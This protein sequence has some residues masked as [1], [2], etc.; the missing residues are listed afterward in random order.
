MIPTSGRATS[1]SSAI[2]PR[3][4]MPIS[5][6]AT[7]VSGSSLQ[8]VSGSPTSLFWLP[9]AATVRACGRQSPARMSLVEVFAVEPVTATTFALLRERTSRAIPARAVKASSGRSA[10]AAPASRASSAKST[11][12]PTA[13]KRS[14]GSTR[15]ESM[16]TPVTAS[17]APGLSSPV[18]TRPISSRVSGIMPGPPAGAGSRARPPGRRRGRSGRRTPVPARGPCRR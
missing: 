12:R 1:Q 15:L 11:P 13:T 7:S 10:A 16:V 17:P 18:A 9:S 2:C 5:T 14:P 4:R 3:P 6:T 8:R